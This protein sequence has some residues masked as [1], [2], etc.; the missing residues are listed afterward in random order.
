M[1]S[2][3]LTLTTTQ[4]KIDEFTLRWQN[5]TVAFVQEALGVGQHDDGMSIEPWQEKA[6]RLFDRMV[7]AKEKSA[8]GEELTDEEKQ[9][10]AKFGITI[11]SGKGAGK[12]AFFAWLS[13]KF[14]TMFHASKIVATAP[15]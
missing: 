13:I 14:L 6:L 4:N 8:R 12:T 10:S 15:K 2:P 11:K 7:L 9:L 1:S 5:D 3:N